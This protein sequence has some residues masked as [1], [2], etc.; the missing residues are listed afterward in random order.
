MCKPVPGEVEG[1]EGGEVVKAGGRQAVGGP[2][3]EDVDEEGDH[4]LH[5]QHQRKA[6]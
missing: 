6:G 2:D 4:N 5:Q 1:R 3:G